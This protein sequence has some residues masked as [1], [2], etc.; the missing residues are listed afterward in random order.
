M[1]CSR[2]ASSS[3]PALIWS[4]SRGSSNPASVASMSSSKSSGWSSA[5]R[6]P[7]SVYRMVQ[8]SM[9]L[10][11][12]RPATIVSP[13]CAPLWAT[14]VACA[15][16]VRRIVPAS[17]RIVSGRILRWAIP[18]KAIQ[19]QLAVGVN[20]PTMTLCTQIL[21][22]VRLPTRTDLPYGAVVWPWSARCRNHSP[23]L[24]RSETARCD[25]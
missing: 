20:V 22:R 1:A 4:N 11:V 25:R 3:R 23:R 14:T 10:S 24:D 15:N 19:I 5:P 18:A 21:Q 13:S 2:S 17:I 7:E 16:S 6:P 8:A 12:T 9:C